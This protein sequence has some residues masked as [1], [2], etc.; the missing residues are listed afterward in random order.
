MGEHVDRIPLC[1]I[2]KYIC[3]ARKYVMPRLSPEAAKVLQ[4]FYLELR[5]KLQNSDSTPITTRQLESII[6][7][8][9]VSY[10]DE[11]YYILMLVL[12]T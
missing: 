2:R 4:N 12:M 6:R 9:E 3:Y 11:I 5:E 1:L 7:L 10:K 8:S